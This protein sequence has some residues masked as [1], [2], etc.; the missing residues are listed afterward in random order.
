[1]SSRAESFFYKGVCHI[2]YSDI[3]YPSNYEYDRTNATGKLFVDRKEKRVGHLLGKPVRALGRLGCM[4]AAGILMAS[5]GAGYH[6]GK[7]MQHAFLWLYHDKSRAKEHKSEL[8]AHAKAFAIDFFMTTCVGAAVVVPP[9]ALAGIITQMAAIALAAVS[10]AFLTCASLKL[11]TSIVLFS[12]EKKAISSYITFVFKNQFGRTKNTR[13]D[14]G[15]TSEKYFKE[16]YKSKIEELL[17]KITTLQEALDDDFQI[18]F[19]PSPHPKQI[20]AYLIKNRHKVIDSTLNV[21]E[22][23][24]KLMTLGHEIDELEDILLNLN[25]LKENGNSILHALTSHYAPH[26]TPVQYPIEEDQVEIFFK[27]EQK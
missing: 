25:N 27:R 14:I 13:P 5:I 18:P 16:Q 20:T 7:L 3:L 10:L 17:F 24:R 19:I 22:E 4:A 2:G 9:L 12:P 15:I 1:M 6:G 21:E 26:V 11:E 8:K 23:I